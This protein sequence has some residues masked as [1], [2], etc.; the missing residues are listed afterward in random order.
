MLTALCLRLSDDLWGDQ[1][2]PTESQV[3]AA[4]LY[5]FGRF[6]QWPTAQ[7]SNGPFTIC[8]F[9]QDVFGSALNAA[10]AG[11]TINGKAVVVRR[12]SSIREGV[13]CQI[14]FISSS[15]ESRLQNVLEVLDKAAVLTVSDIPEFSQRGGMI[16]FLR[17]GGRVRFLVN[18][19][20]AQ[21]A[22]LTL[23]S[24]LLKVAVAVQTDAPLAGKP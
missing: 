5:N 6:V 17:N 11:A 1:P 13:N 4:Y 22:G 16:Q 23:S 14:L 19:R 15:E 12:I 3:Q 7:V 2:R 10:V 24:E 9:G 21:N 20:A 18:L 8:V